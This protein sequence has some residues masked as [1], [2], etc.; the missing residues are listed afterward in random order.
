MILDR[1]MKE[2][3]DTS[4][5]YVGRVSPA[6]KAARAVWN[7]VCFLLFRP[8]GT[9]V[10]RPWRIL[11]L[12]AFGADLM[13]D[14]EVY[15]SAR[16]W[17]PWNLR[18]GHRSCLGPGVICYNQAPVVVGDDAVVS[19]YAYLCTASH[20]VDKQ[21]TASDSLVIAPIIIGD[22]AWIGVRAYVGMG[23]SIGRAAV[24]GATASVYKDVADRAIVGGNPAVLLKM[25]M[26]D[27][28]G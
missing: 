4:R 11:L 19:Q 8:F 23:V 27:G 25:R 22:G 16:V 20:D 1:M 5:R 21:N 3:I 12:R 6:N 26:L 28:I 18:M 7:V 15:A 9:K 24:V 13:W 14:S 2:T 17:A 10:F